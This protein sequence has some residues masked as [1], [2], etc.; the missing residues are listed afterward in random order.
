MGDDM[1]DDASTIEE[2]L[3]MISKQRWY[4]YIWMLKYHIKES[5]QK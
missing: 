5:R 2:M 4:L 3:N 1:M